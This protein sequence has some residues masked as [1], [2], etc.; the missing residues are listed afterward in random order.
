MLPAT[1]SLRSRRPQ[2]SSGPRSE[3][4][5]ETSLQ[6]PVQ[7][8]PH[9]HRFLRAQTGRRHG[10]PTRS[11]C[12]YLRGLTT[13]SLAIASYPHRG[14]ELTLGIKQASCQATN[15]MNSASYDF[16]RL[17]NLTRIVTPDA[18]RHQQRVRNPQITLTVARE[19]LRLGG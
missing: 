8:K 15:A 9:G 2:R 7:R 18:H 6:R 1:P 14:T 19:D 12:G 5:G 11:P 10:E 13:R 3:D 17:P 16:T 4:L